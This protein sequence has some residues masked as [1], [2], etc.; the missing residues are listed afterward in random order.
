MALSQ[1]ASAAWL[2]G[3]TSELGPAPAVFSS[4]PGH[5]FIGTALLTGTAAAQRTLLLS[6]IALNDWNAS[7]QTGLGSLRGRAYRGCT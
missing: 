2:L 5:R 6:L 3:V 7:S 4:R 1:Q